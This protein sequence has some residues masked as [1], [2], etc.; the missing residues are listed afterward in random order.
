[1]NPRRSGAI[2]VSVR[3]A[4]SV[5]MLAVLVWRL[6]DVEL[7]DLGPTWSTNSLW[8]MLGAAATMTTAFLLSTMRWNRVLAAMT[9]PPR[10]RRMFS[11]F[12]AGQ[13]VSNV[14]PTAFGGDIVRVSRLGSDISDYPRAFASVT[15]ERLT[16]W[17][18]LPLISLTALAVQ[19][20]LHDLANATYFTIAVSVATLLALV[21]ILSVA[22]NR[23]F[24]ADLDAMFGWRRFF[25]AIHIGVD[26]L[27]RRPLIAAEVVAVGATF[28]I[29]QSLVVWMTAQAIGLDEVTIGVALAFFPVAAIAQN[30]PIGIGGLGVRESTFVL[31]FGAVGAPKAPSITLGLL[32]YGLTVI[33]SALGAPAFAFGTRLKS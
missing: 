2:K 13:F 29:L 31:L 7:K 11:F 18:V 8:W 16:G 4:L 6:P 3:I 32:V 33:T 23:R 27:R 25:V 19:P 14:L 30:L 24:N 20:R 22:A 21:A 15:I 26:A 10:F 17:L 28:Q 9:P 1:M 5:V 12:L